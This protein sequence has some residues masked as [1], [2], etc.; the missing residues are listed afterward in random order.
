MLVY[1]SIYS[2]VSYGDE[3]ES[4]FIF[5]FDTKEKKRQNT[6]QSW[7]RSLVQ[8]LPRVSVLFLLPIALLLPYMC[9]KKKLICLVNKTR[10]DHKVLGPMYFK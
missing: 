8:I 9:I 2:G 6:W 3:R 10:I 5:S 1:W 4:D 7:L